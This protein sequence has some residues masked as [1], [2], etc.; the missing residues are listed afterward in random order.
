[1]DN[2]TI[3]LHTSKS[4]QNFNNW[5]YSE[6]KP[7]LNGNILEVGSGLGTFTEKI[8]ND[9]PDSQIVISDI[10]LEYLKNLETRFSNRD[11]IHFIEFD[12]SNSSHANNIKTKINASLAL[13]VLEHI[14]DDVQ[15]IKNVYDI[16]EPGGKFVILVPCHKFLFNT[17]DKTAMH[18]RRYTKKELSDKIKKTGFKIKSCFYFNFFS[19]FGWYINGNLFKKNLL[20]KSSVSLF[21]RLVPIFISIE[22]FILR[23]K[24]G[25]SLIIVLEK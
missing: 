17:L 16:L 24:A 3:N 14:E 23:K 5:M 15:A 20:N 22:R 6:I 18:C 10:N 7:H 9:F 1:M 25:I 2:S 8:V 11:Q 19:I 13:N 21:D 12:L 4:A